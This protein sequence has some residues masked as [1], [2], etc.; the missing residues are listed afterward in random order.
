MK[1]NRT[2]KN[3][4]RPKNR[5]KVFEVAQ[6]VTKPIYILT[7]RGKRFELTYKE[8]V[9]LLGLLDG[10]KDKSYEEVEE[11]WEED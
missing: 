4:S 6:K 2:K 3:T 5:S 7:I 9:K 10:V 8:L 1:S 11:F